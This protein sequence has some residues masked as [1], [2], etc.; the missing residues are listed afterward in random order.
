MLPK[1]VI[2]CFA[3]K[4]PP[5]VCG[6]ICMKGFSRNIKQD[7]KRSFHTTY[8]DEICSFT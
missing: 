1:A 6:R 8:Y 4:N 3:I 2:L 7:Q 5:C